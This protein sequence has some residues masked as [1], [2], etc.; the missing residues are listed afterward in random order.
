M[1]RTSRYVLLLGLLL[2]L[3]LTG[4]N[5]DGW[6]EIHGNVTYAGQAVEKGQIIFLPANGDGPTAAIQ[7]V[8]G[9]YRLRL[10]PGK[11]RVQIVGYKVVGHHHW[12]PNAPSTPLV[13]DLEQYLPDRYNGKSTLMKEITSGG[14]YDFNLEK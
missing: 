12:V 7:V 14:V 8:N 3:T 4:C 5:R 1:D 10:A 13:E 9:Q 11:K 6:L 2:T